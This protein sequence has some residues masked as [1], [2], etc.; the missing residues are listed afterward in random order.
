MPA[1]IL[2]TGMREIH[3]VHEWLDLADFYACADLVLRALTLRAA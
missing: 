3:T 2:G 1:V